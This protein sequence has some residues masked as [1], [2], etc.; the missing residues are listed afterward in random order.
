MEWSIFEHGHPCVN[1]ENKRFE[2]ISYLLLSPKGTDPKQSTI[3]YYHGWHSSKEFKRFEAMTLASFGYR[4]IVPDALYH[5]ER[6]TID[7][8]APDSIDRYLW[9]II[10][11]SIKESGRFIVHLDESY[12]IQEEQIVVMGCSMGAM[13]AAGVFSNNP[14]IKG[15]TSISGLNAWGKAIMQGA[16]PNPGEY[17]DLIHQLDLYENLGRLNERPILMLHGMDDNLLPIDLQRDFYEKAKE[18]N[19][20]VEMAE[21]D[22][23]GH[24]FTMNMMQ[25]LIVWLDFYSK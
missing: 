4:V 5:G 15:L 10:V 14:Q 23:V 8:D 9:E 3:I 12:G 6:G 1:I 2:E 20:R 18:I 7:Y 25:K 19:S 13:I 11:Q 22:Q 24:R 21:Y 16:M 17:K